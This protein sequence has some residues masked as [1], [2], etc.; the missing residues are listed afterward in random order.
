MIKVLY[1]IYYKVDLVGNYIVW[2]DRLGLC[3]VLLSRDW[4]IMNDL[5]G[6]I[7]SEGGCLW[8]LYGWCL[9][10]IKGFGLSENEVMFF[11]FRGYV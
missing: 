10:W 11:V 1:G 7:W 8:M 2:M 3:E 5:R 4:Y 9:I 6:G